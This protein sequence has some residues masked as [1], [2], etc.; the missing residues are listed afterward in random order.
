MYFKFLIGLSC[1][2]LLSNR[3][4]FAL[5]EAE[6]AYNAGMKAYHRNE[7][8]N[9]V[10]A[11]ENSLGYDTSLY[12]SYCM[13]GLSYILNDE[14]VKGVQTYQEAIKKFPNEWNAYILLAEYY[15]TQ[16][17]NSEALSYYLQASDLLPK[18]DRKKYDTKI[19]ELREK[20][21]EEW[22]VSETEKEK[23]LS[24]IF[25][26]LDMGK[27]RVSLVE[28]KESAI[29]IVYALKSENYKAGK[30]SQILDLTCTYTDK[31]D[32]NS[33]NQI[34]EWMATN[35]KHSNADMDTVTKTDTSRLYE[36]NMHEQKNQILGYI[37]PAPKGFCIAQ[38]NYK[39]IT[40]K[41][42]AQWLDNITKISVRN[43]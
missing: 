41:E 8:Q 32:K 17:K 15:E 18:K 43:F 16:K 37:F 3:P 25:T 21:K 39:K 38:F 4:C 2:F 31:Q 34:N 23:I 22:S 33:F 13:L 24:N 12:K 9:A 26:P 5:N 6:A 28:Q 27:W 42:R 10:Y 29:H 1:A 14:P 30:W 19:K 20:Q 11:F 36:V 35:Y 7:F 40:P